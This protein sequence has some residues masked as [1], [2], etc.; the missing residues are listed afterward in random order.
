MRR[1]SRGQSTVELAVS[2]I[3]FVTV[4]MF[5]IHFAEVGYLSLKVHEAAVSPLWDATALRTHRIRHHPNNIGDFSHIHSIPPSVNND[6][7]RRYRDFDGRSSTSE[8]GDRRISH[9]FTE[10]RGM[11]VQCHSDDAIAFDV[12]RGRRPALLAPRPGNHAHTPSGQNRG[13]PTGSVLDGIFENVGGM[14]CTAEAQVQTLPTLPTRFLEGARGF[15]QKEHAVRRVMRACAAGQAMGGACPGRYGILLG[16]F[17]FTDLDVSG[18]CPLQP[19]QPEAPC[20]ENQAFY[21]AARKVF[22]ANGRSAGRDATKFAE[23]FAGFSPIDESGFFMS[24]RGEEDAYVELLTPPGEPLDE[25]DR[26]R[27]TGGPDHRPAA[28]RPNNNCFLGLNGC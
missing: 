5:G 23:H 12:P 7:R 6:A 15:F 10:V 11:Q 14:S 20:G 13:D 26:P 17:S 2:L 27:N 16:D 19:E 8:R 25:V 1:T 28:Y 3:V 9:V 22:D 4:V 18:H 24:Y 21:Y